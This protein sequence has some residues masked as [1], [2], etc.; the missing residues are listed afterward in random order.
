MIHVILR[1]GCSLRCAVGIVFRSACA[2]LTL[3]LTT[4]GF[5]ADLEPDLG[6]VETLAQPDAHWLITLGFLAGA[7]VWDA[8]SGEM[9]GKINISDYTSAVG[10]DEARGMIYVPASYYSRGTYGERSD[11]LVFNDLKTLAAVAEVAV[12]KKLAAVFH[13]A[14]INPVGDRFYGLYNMTPAMSVSIVD[15]EKR[16]FVEEISTAGCAF[17]YPV[18]GQRFMQLCG[19]GTVQV[20]SLGN[21]GKESGRVRSN[22]FFD[23]DTDPV[24]DFAVANGDN[25]ILISYAGLVYEVSIDD[26]IRVSKPWSILTDEDKEEGWRV[27]GSEPFAFNANTGTLFTLVHQGENDTHEEDGTHLWAL[28]FATH[29]RGYEIELEEPIGV[30]GVS[31]DSKPLLYVVGGFPNTISVHDAQTGRH[32]RTIDEAGSYAGHVQTF[33]GGG[34]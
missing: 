18:S 30:I 19:D 31:Q 29:R 12:P 26:K 6:R 4:A 3:L 33:S 20:I 1:T 23:P 15:V 7:Y 13:R 17:V 32:L 27:G 9:K 22:K 2:A 5:A 21:D 16:V 28:D 11:V 34:R 14:V 10:I 8:D 24:F 25:W